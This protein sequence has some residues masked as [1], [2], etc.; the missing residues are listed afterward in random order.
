AIAARVGKDVAY[1]TR[2]LQLVSLAEQPRRALAERLITIDH[3]L[4]LAR[5]GVD[6]QDK[7]L[8][9]ALKYGDGKKPVDQVIDR[10]LAER[11]EDKEFVRYWQPNSPIDLK[12]HIEESVGRKHSRAPW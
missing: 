7:A 9:Y 8:L 1:V 6:E 4:L 2:R 12:E 5:L 11:K 10:I 3:A